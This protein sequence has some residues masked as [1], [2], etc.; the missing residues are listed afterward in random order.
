MLLNTLEEYLGDQHCADKECIDQIIKYLRSMDI[1]PTY[2]MV[3]DIERWIGD[4]L[5][6][7]LQTV[8]T[9][10]WHDDLGNKLR[11]IT[12]ENIDVEV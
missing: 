2:G 10:N 6:G 11:Y 4:N 7:I 12:Q 8:D 5:L 9:D 1:T 3:F